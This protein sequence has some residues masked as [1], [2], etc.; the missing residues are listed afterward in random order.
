ML[1]RLNRLVQ[2]KAQKQEQTAEAK[3]TRQQQKKTHTSN[4]G[5]FPMKIHTQYTFSFF[6]SENST[7]IH[8]CQTR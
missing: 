6:R 1:H 7:Q 4:I 5:R 8:Q 2:L 3:Q